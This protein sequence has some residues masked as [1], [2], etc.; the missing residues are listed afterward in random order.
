[1]S[2]GGSDLPPW[3]PLLVAN[4]LPINYFKKKIILVLFIVL[5]KYIG[6]ILE[7]RL[8]YVFIIEIY[9]YTFLPFSWDKVGFFFF[10]IIII[11]IIIIKELSET[12][13]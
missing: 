3:R 2:S 9:L 10:Y 5:V 6:F 8:I 7:Y 12:Y 4:S 1:M 13:D 11:I